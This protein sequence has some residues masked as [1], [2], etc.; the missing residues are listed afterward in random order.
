MAR[1]YFHLRE[2]D[3]V[4]LDTEGIDLPD[5]QSARNR[6]IAEA[7]G[8]LAVELRER[9]LVDLSRSIDVADEGGTIVHSLPFDDIVIVVRN[10]PTL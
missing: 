6:A 10:D 7:K 4:F 5:V 9:S 3:G 1:F 8:L 2:G